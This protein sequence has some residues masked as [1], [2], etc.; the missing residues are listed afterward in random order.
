MFTTVTLRHCALA[1]LVAG[2]TALTAHTAAA[3]SAIDNSALS[4][5][6]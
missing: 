6:H 1:L 5:A 3:Q 2:S 4:A